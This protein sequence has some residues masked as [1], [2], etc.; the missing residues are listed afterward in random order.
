MASVAHPRAWLD[1]R[2]AR[3]EAD[4]WI[5]HG[6]ES[7]WPWRV[8]E[9][10]CDHE[11]KSCARAL[12]GVL[13]E[14]EGSKLPGATPL[15]RAALRPHLALLQQLESRLLDGEPVSAQGMLAVSSLLTDPGSCLVD[16]QADVAC[17]LHDVL[18]RLEVRH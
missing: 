5:R 4:E 8:A 6:F 2:R 15:R 16:P 7:R 1:R 14:V 9:L 18:A 11:R 12:H 10:T 13:G 3:R 17:C